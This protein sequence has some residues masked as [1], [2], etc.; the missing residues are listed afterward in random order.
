M[1]VVLS[2]VAASN[3][4]HV[5]FTLIQ[6]MKNSA[7]GVLCL[8]K[9]HAVSCACPSGVPLHGKAYRVG[10]CHLLTCS[11]GRSTAH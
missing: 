3:E 8:T 7:A 11:S 5:S 4:R 6:L 10:I 9:K 2:P 1:C